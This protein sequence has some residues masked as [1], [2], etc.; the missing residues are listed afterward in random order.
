M[1]WA[2][3]V[4]TFARSLVNA[5]NY[6]QG[7]FI[8]DF[9]TVIDK[10]SDEV[11]T[12]DIGPISILPL[13]H[14]DPVHNAS[15][16]PSPNMTMKESLSNRLAANLSA[17]PD[18]DL[19]RSDPYGGVLKTSF[20]APV[21]EQRP[22]LA[23]QQYFVAQK[24]ASMGANLSYQQTYKGVALGEKKVYNTGYNLDAF[25][26]HMDTVMLPSNLVAAK[27]EIESYGMD[28]SSTKK[29]IEI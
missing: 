19:I 25:V 4:G 6:N 16:T 15:W 23:F 26:V 20:K 8:N 9:I 18:T 12:G 7:F 5:T 10:D 2:V 13:E 24:P 28:F 1:H 27:Q 21:D 11:K 17:F 29:V 14:K 22:I 3:G